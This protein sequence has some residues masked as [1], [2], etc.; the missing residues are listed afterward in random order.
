M[1]LLVE[2]Q[3]GLRRVRSSRRSDQQVGVCV[4]TLC[5]RSVFFPQSTRE[6]GYRDARCFRQ[7]SLLKLHGF[8]K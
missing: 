5:L 8:C 7:L 1:T 3:V 4:H 6:D 2:E